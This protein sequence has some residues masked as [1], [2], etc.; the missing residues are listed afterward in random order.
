M[1]TTYTWQDL[2]GGTTRMR[3]RNRGEPR[4]FAK[5]T[6]PVMARTVGHANRNDLQRLKSILERPASLPSA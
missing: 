2:P 4:G 5:V 6:G 3:L 1:E